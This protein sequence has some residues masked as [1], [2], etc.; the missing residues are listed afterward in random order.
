MSLSKLTKSEGDSPRTRFVYVAINPLLL[1]YKYY[2][3]LIRDGA[4]N[5]AL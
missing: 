1:Y 2:Q 4:S 5:S 3:D